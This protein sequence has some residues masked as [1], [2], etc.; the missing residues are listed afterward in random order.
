MVEESVA[1]WPKKS[2]VNRYLAYDEDGGTIVSE[3]QV[4]KLSTGQD[5]TLKGYREATVDCWG[6]D[7]HQVKYLDVLI[8]NS[9]LGEDEEVLADERQFVWLLSLIKEDHV[10][11]VDE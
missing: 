6:P 2:I 10:K 7:S 8:K 4:G 1:S 9:P 11:W 5:S 3:R